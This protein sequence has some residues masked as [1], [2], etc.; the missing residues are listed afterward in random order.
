MKLDTTSLFDDLTSF[1]S[2][3]QAVE[4]IG[5]D[6]LWIAETQ[7]DP[8]L[9]CALIAEHTRKLRFGTQV[10]IA[11][12]RSPTTLAHTAWDL[13]RTSQGRFILG[14]GTQVKAH[15]ERRFGMPWPGS[16][17]GKLREQITAIRAL[18]RTWQT[19]QPLNFRGE[20]YKLTLMSPFFN[21]GPI[22]YP[23]IPIYI[24]GV[25]TG[26]ARLAGEVADGFH[27]H[28]LHSPRYLA[29]VILPKIEQSAAHYGR[30]REHICISV[31]AFVIT[32][33]IEEQMVRQQIAFYASTPSYRVVLA[34]H[35]WESIGEQLS[36]LAARG[37]W[38]EMPSLINDD[39]LETFAV[40]ADP[41]DLAACLIKRYTG[42]ADRLTLY[43]PFIQ[44]ER[45]TFWQS[46]LQSIDGRGHAL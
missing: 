27:V 35:G 4:G 44:G 7:H 41:A 26:L 29:E 16:V 36:S 19:G 9:P 25:N 24:A 40:R 12:A 5:F 34:I 45:D 37:Q 39:M 18:W 20:H 38:G 2:L 23:D 3:A 21:P 13:A 6:A 43:I 14:L 30:S 15:I 17:T 46:L 8:F 10:A 22:D 1:P 11:F 31:S 42:L 28:P 33:T 32:S